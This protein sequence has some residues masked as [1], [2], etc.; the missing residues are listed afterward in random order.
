MFNNNKKKPKTWALRS[1]KLK[2]KINGRHPMF[3]D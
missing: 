1:A 2:A 3:M